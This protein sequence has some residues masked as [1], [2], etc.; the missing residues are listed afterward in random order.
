MHKKIIVFGLLG[1]FALAGN[2]FALGRR[3]GRCLREKP[4]IKFSIGGGLGFAGLSMEDFDTSGETKIFEAKLGVDETASVDELSSSFAVPVEARV[5]FNLK[6]GNKI[7]F[8]IGFSRLAGNYTEKLTGVNMTE[9]T[10]ID[11]EA[12]VVPI[13]IYYKIPANDNTFYFFG[14]GISIYSSTLEYDKTETEPGE[15]TTFERGKLEAG[16][17]GTGFHFIFGA[18]HFFKE[19]VAISFDI[20][21]NFATLSNFKGI[22]VD[23]EGSGKN[24]LLIMEKDSVTG[25]ESLEVKDVLLPLADNERPAEV[26]FNGIRINI[27]IRYYF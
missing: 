22:L 12:T 26:N 4:T 9:T 27:G 20:G 25:R 11:V 13:S 16:S 15:P 8:G 14:G 7:A 5:D 19:N 2:L 24:K 17:G 6:N 18:K 1:V 23:E 3:G 21:G 10:S